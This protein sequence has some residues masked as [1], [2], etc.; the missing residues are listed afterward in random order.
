VRAAPKPGGGH[1][2]APARGGKL[3]A[4]AGRRLSLIVSCLLAALAGGAREAGA[5]ELHSLFDGSCRRTTGILVHVGAER[6]TMVDLDGALV[7]RDR[8]QI[9]GIALHKTLE[10]PLAQVAL[11]SELKAY[12]RDVWV[13]DDARPTFT[14]W[15]TAFFDDLFLYFD[16]DGQT[17][18]LDPEEIRRIL[19]STIRAPRVT[20]R[21]HAPVQL[22][23]PSEVVPCGRGAVSREAVL[24]MRV[25]AD[26]IKVGDYLGKLEQRYLDQAGF[27]ER[28]R[29]YAEPFLFGLESRLGLLYDPEWMVPF[30]LYFRWSNGRPYRFQSLSVV[31]NASHEWLPFV[32]PT[33]SA[34]SD[35]KS[36]FFS[37]TFIGHIL[38]LPAGTDAFVLDD[39]D[40][41]QPGDD[42]EVEHSYNYVLLLGAD[43]WRLSGS[44]GASYLTSRINLPETP[45]RNVRA[46]G[47]SPTVRLR[48]QGP[49]LQLRALYFRTRAS[50]P[51]EDV[52]SDDDGVDG[53]EGVLGRYRWKLDTVRLG[54]TWKP[55]PTVEVLVDQIGSR[56]AYW[57]EYP[58][59]SVE[60]DLWE[61]TTSGELAVSFGRYVTVKGIIRFYVKNRDVAEP[62][63]TEVTLVST[64]FGGALEFVF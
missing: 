54:A 59:S 37:A 23:F 53:D 35:I 64:R 19:P 38:S 6:V 3:A 25:I 24:P 2:W 60:L 41:L 33:I 55:H 1:A 7:V 27:E 8:D 43:W 52:F 5:T 50:G 47:A 9:A 56:G 42:P 11:S 12:L 34:R 28:T 15:T 49:S 48:Y 51:V 46:D 10:N 29:V 40:F 16:L 20:P 39:P 14:G 13:G 30:P 45:A 17:H 4:V 62:M 26:R 22:A 63:S 18:V 44:F 36:H 58:M 31:G 21:N 61:L 57:D 32:S